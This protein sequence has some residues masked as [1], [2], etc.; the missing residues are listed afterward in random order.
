VSSSRRGTADART[1]PAAVDL[2]G[3]RTV[4]AALGSDV[5]NSTLKPAV[6]VL[7]AVYD[8]PIAM[9]AQA[10]DSIQRQTFTDFEFLIVDDGSRDLV[11]R[12][13]LAQ[14]AKEDTRIRI[15]TE[16]HRGLTTSLNHGLA[17]AR[18]TWI[19]RQD[20]DDWS[21]PT[22][23]ERQVAHF[24]EHP[25]TI[26]PGTGV[27]THQQD[28]RLLWPLR[29]PLRHADILR[30]LPRG[31]PFV[32]GS[33]MFPRAEAVWAG[34]YR[35]EFRCSQDYDFLWR[36]AERGT[37]ANLAEPLYHYR[38]TS[39]S[40]SAGRAQ[41]QARAHRAIQLLAASRQRGEPQDILG[42]L[43]E[44]DGPIERA[45]LKQA[46]HLML[47][48]D[49]RQACTAYSKLLASHPQNLLTWGK[50]ARLGVFCTF[51]RLREVCFR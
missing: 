21:E 30:W 11:V 39:G 10:M 24:R 44:A 50:L 22:R 9:L 31:N 46:D 51:P 43:A 5:L 17:L 12:S 36:M 16:P 19:A 6:T 35:E 27:W 20:A 49:Y 45:L 1:R 14:R 47:A 34:G 42:A 37:A 29:L 33:V 41:E 28:G 3:V 2:V 40:V 8:P 4:G 15:L 25:E 13:F 48:G 32:H 18:G 26:V 7:M 38:Y 23:L